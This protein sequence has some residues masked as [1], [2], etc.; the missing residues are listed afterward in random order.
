MRKRTSVAARPH[1]E[2][3][4]ITTSIPVVNEANLEEAA[5]FGKEAMRQAREKHL[6]GGDIITVDCSGT[7]MDK[8]TLAAAVSRLYGDDTSANVQYAGTTGRSV[9]F[10]VIG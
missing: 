10:R 4:P 1:Y 5:A 3:R 7:T 8:N 9:D 6:Q 2:V